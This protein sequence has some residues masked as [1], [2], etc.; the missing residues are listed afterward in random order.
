MQPRAHLPLGGLLVGP[1]HRLQ[2]RRLAALEVRL[3]GGGVPAE[4]RLGRLE[5]SLP[6]PGQALQLGRLLPLQAQPHLD[7]EDLAPLGHVVAH[8]L[9]VA[10]QVGQR[11]GALSPRRRV[12][13][14]L[15]GGGTTACGGGA[16]V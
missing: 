14:R 8:A 6:V 15:A 9:G 7:L 4:R 12:R 2:Q 13:G 10:P 5:G 1:A 3:K 11:A 16:E